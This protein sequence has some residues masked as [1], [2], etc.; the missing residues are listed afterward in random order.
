MKRFLLIL[1]ILAL[2]LG[3]Q[4]ASDLTMMPDDIR[5][6]KDPLVAGDE[7][8]IY[9]TI[10][11]NGDVDT[12]GYVT[13]YS[14]ATVIGSPVQISLL[15]GGNPEEVYV[16][17]IVP[18]SEFNIMAIIQ[19]TTP[20]DT[21][22]NNNSAITQMIQPVFDE[23]RDG[24]EDQYDNCPEVYNT[25]Q[26]DSDGDGNGDDCDEDDD[27]DTLSDA[28]E[29]GLGTNPLSA[30]TDN[31]GVLDPDDAYPNDPTRTEVEPEP[32]PVPEPEPEPEPESEEQPVTEEPSEP[33]EKKPLPVSESFQQLVQEVAT[34]I[35]QQS[36]D[37]SS[38]TTEGQEDDQPSVNRPGARSDALH[39]SPNAVFGYSRDSWNTYTFS[40][41]SPQTNG[42]LYV[43]DFGDGTTSSKAEVE[44]TYAQ[45]GAYTVS[46]T[47]TDKSG[48]VST[49]RTTVLVP[50]F[51]LGNW[52]IVMAVSVLAILLI[53]GIIS[54][55]R[56]GSPKKR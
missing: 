32:E 56:L 50:F 10:D 1:A 39:I 55:I 25:R 17:F 12:S 24:I 14:G 54:F 16:D 18:S 36:A 38:E 13:F 8:R 44:H 4:A 46:L 43:W 2:P 19:G 22:N 7:V 52:V 9:A 6:S 41:R 23:D 3:A 35:K 26:L 20:E 29:V 27:N 49:E 15:A 30:D 33:A 40:V 5:F 11:N 42:T 45:S 34:T 48:I 47:M 51:H 37:E 28:L 53:V 31:D 21:N